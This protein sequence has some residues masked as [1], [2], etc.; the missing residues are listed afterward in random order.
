MCFISRAALPLSVLLGSGAVFAAVP[1]IG[2]T[3]AIAAPPGLLL[4]LKDAA[5]SEFAGF[6]WDLLVVFGPTVGLFV[7]LAALAVRL[8]CRSR[9][10]ISALVLLGA[11][12][13]AALYLL[14]PLAYSEPF[15]RPLP[16]WAS[17]AEASIVI[18][19][20]AA[21]PLLRRVHS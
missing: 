2:Y 20:I 16:W 13:F 19:C 10:G 15:V 12:A 18:A 9:P 17:A 14:V 5:S 4:W 1:L 6:S 7:F 3:M 11:G 21:F 8:I